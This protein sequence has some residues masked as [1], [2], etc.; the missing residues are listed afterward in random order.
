MKHFIVLIAIVTFI[1]AQQCFMPGS[2]S[3]AR[4]TDLGRCAK[5]ESQVSCCNTETVAKA[6]QGVDKKSCNQSPVQGSYI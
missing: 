2:P 6:F 4:Y 3:P 1:C 5:Y